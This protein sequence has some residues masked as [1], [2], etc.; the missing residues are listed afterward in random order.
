MTTDKRMKILFYMEIVLVF[1]FHID[2]T[3]LYNYKIGT[4][5]DLDKAFRFKVAYNVLLSCGIL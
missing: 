3:L 4:W 1:T 5:Y 2:S